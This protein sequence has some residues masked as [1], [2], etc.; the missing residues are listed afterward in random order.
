MRIVNCNS[1]SAQRRILPSA[2]RASSRVELYIR[3]ERI[4][5]ATGAPQQLG[6][7]KH[8]VEPICIIISANSQT[9][10]LKFG[11]ASPMGSSKREKKREIQRKEGKEST[12]GANG[13]LARL[14]GK[15]L[16]ISGS[17][18]ALRHRGWLAQ[19][20]GRVRRSLQWAKDVARLDSRASFV[21]PERPIVPDKSGR[22]NSRQRS[23]I[24]LGVQ[25]RI[26]NSSLYSA[27]VVVSAELDCASTE[28][29][30]ERSPD[31][32]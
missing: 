18:A 1:I 5:E 17:R 8:S 11:W 22:T 12:Q 27:T 28:V 3:L 24:A 9:F 4:R 23:K 6:K 16:R 25:H 7:Q 14:P 26:R 32:P 31:V 15:P 21:L 29:D 13:R 2:V 19:T 30:V 20:R 10:P